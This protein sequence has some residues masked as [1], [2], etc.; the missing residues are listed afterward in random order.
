MSKKV[1][2]PTSSKNDFVDKLMSMSPTAINEFIKKNGRQKIKRVPLMH[3]VVREE[4]SNGGN[5][6][7]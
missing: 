4:K 2:F 1:N 6:Y 5:Y 3:Q 7:G